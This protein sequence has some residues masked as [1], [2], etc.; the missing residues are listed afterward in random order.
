M[1]ARIYVCMHAMYV[2]MYV[3]THACMRTCLCCQQVHILPHLWKLYA[4]WC[5]THRTPYDIPYIPIRHTP[6]DAQYMPIHHAP[7]DAL[8]IPHTSYLI[9]HTTYRRPIHHA[10][11]TQSWLVYKNFC[12]Y[13]C[14]CTCVCT[15]VCMF[16]C[17]PM[18]MHARTNTRKH[19]CMYARS[20]GGK[21]NERGPPAEVLVRYGCY[22]QGHHSLI[23]E[24]CRS[25][26]R[27]LL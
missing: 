14:V 2:C 12:V 9:P 25:V 26:K 11:I 21:L 20:A 18:H 4:T 6:Y 7:H 1:H 16:V 22:A 27:D 8:C 19:A 5:T 24:V 13:M 17:M 3:C 10:L 23:P 15:C